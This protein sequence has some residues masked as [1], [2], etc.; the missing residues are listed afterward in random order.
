MEIHHQHHHD[1][2]QH[3]EKL[4]KHYALEFF[5]L[6]LAVFCGFL[7]ENY[8][9]E[10]VDHRREKE[11]MQSMLE[12]LRSDTG[13]YH[14]LIQLINHKMALKDSLLKTLSDPEVF[15]NSNKAYF[16]LTKSYHFPD[17]VYSD[18]TI[19]QLKNSGG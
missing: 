1:H 15:A 9:E 4:W 13:Q 17:F 16:Y 5:M 12:D 11:Y 2:P 3:K 7:A 14:Q 8:R 6:F 18:R 19:Q 10:L